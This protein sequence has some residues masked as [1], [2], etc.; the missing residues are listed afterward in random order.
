MMKVFL[1]SIGCRLNQAEIEKYAAQFAA[2]GHILVRT[3]AEA[4]VVVINTCTVTAEASSDSRE[5]I[6][7][8]GRAGNAKI[9]TT[10][11]LVS[12]EPETM[13]SM[14]HVLANITNDQKDDLVFFISDL[15][16]E[17]SG[18]P[19]KNMKPSRGRD[20]ARGLSSRHR[21]VVI[22]IAH[23]ALPDW[24]AGNPEALTKK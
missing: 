20:T 3:P 10:G 14:P 17:N 18:N 22:I 21:M 15:L 23:F 13:L 8:A 24:H 9:V 16:K 11:C 4:D 19:V 2:N 12:L 6:R 1:D 7:Q 5:K